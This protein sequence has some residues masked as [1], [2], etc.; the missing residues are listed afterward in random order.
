[1]SEVDFHKIYLKRLNGA[2]SP[3]RRVPSQKSNGLVFVCKILQK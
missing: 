3:Y 2:G 1:M